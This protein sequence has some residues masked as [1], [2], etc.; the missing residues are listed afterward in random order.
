MS[1][2]TN[3]SE[4]GTISTNVTSVLSLAR[5]EHASIVIDTTTG[6]GT[7]V[8][9]IR[10][11]FSLPSIYSNTSTNAQYVTPLTGDINTGGATAGIMIVSTS[12]FTDS[13]NTV[14][15]YSE[16]NG[17]SATS[18]LNSS[19][20]NHNVGVIP[21]YL[22]LP[23]SKAHKVD[24]GMSSV[25][26]HPGINW[27]YPLAIIQPF[28]TSLTLEEKNT[29]SQVA[30]AFS[31]TTTPIFLASSTNASWISE[32]YGDMPQA[33]NPVY[34]TIAIAG[35]TDTAILFSGA[36]AYPFNRT[37]SVFNFSYDLSYTVTNY[38]S[39]E[40]ISASLSA[41]HKGSVNISTALQTN[42]PGSKFDIAWS[43][44]GK[45]L[46]AICTTTDTSA[47]MVV[48]SMD[49]ST[50]IISS[51]ATAALT[52]GTNGSY[53]NVIWSGN[54][55]LFISGASNNTTGILYN[56]NTATNALTLGTFPST[57]NGNTPIRIWDRFDD[58]N[59][60]VTISNTYTSTRLN[61]Y[62]P[63]TSVKT[64]FDDRTIDTSF[65]TAV[66]TRGA[67]LIGPSFGSSNQHQAF[68]Y[69]FE[70]AQETQFINSSSGTVKHTTFVYN[71]SNTTISKVLNSSDLAA[72]NV[73]KYSVPSFEKTKYGAI[74]C[75]VQTSSQD[76]SGF[77]NLYGSSGTSKQFNRVW[78]LGDFRT[79]ASSCVFGPSGHVSPQV[80]WSDSKIK[81]EP[82]QSVL[83]SPVSNRLFSTGANATYPNL[84]A[85][86]EA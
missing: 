25:S 3:P 59:L 2:N 28:G 9:N 17:V 63:S 27:M 46:A 56:F 84:I 44:D 67:C 78:I 47:A 39:A 54:S 76:F 12:S 55:Q 82:G 15:T 71:S 64:S 61:I 66:T 52:G 53:K 37:G 29:G 30:V 11:Q 36:N 32:M 33:F 49:T 38:G 23:N 14:Q 20:Q 81:L 24:V 62:N 80:V 16:T 18:S 69:Q 48:C 22:N 83:I 72:N 4:L 34:K 13:L 5:E 41:A 42:G 43:T 70:N 77:V 74:M 40:I 7:K 50:L 31:S 57:L 79:F 86:S 85:V 58:G 6:K 73:S 8:Y 19:P 1:I 60:L 51:V 26:A 45:Y 65:N 75:T 35:A 21:D 68:A 10:N